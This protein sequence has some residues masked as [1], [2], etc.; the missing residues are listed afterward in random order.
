MKKF[1][2]YAFGTVCV[3]ILLMT[4]YSVTI[5]NVVTNRNY[6]NNVNKEK[7]VS[8]VVLGKNAT[9]SIKVSEEVDDSQELEVK[10]EK[11]EVPV[12]TPEPTPVP[13]PVPTPTPAPQVTISY[14]PIDTSSYNVIS[15]EVVN[16]SHFGPDCNGCG[17]GY[18]ASGY[19]VGEGRINYPDSTFG[20]VRI[21]AAD[22][23]YP[24]GS[25]VRLTYNG[26]VII[27]IVLDRGGGIGDG[28]KYQ[29]DLLDVSEA[30]SSRLG[31]MYGA[32]LE[33][34][35]SGY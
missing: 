27:A 14:N 20:N 11:V 21:V 9:E 2:N 35:R 1:Y 23:K 22:Y 17:S 6:A 30:E 7:I 5:I 31:V 12:A 24:T 13:T 19:Y 29:I 33:L 16:I 34:L 4:L 10:E 18:V 3:F 15:S 26:N 28:R 32:T 8:S 25:I